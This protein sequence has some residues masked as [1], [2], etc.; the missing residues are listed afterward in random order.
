MVIVREDKNLITATRGDTI[1]IS[2]NIVDDLGNPY[3]PDLENDEL[4]FALK[5]NYNDEEPLL[6][7]Q[8]PI[9]TCV[10]R[11]E[12]EETKHLI[13]PGDYVYDIQLTYGDGIVSTIVP[14]KDSRVAKLKIVEEVL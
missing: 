5:K 14:N 3:E 7:K 13:Q 12:S 4:R 9:D 6:V 1:L 10:L 11:I 2:V 8:I